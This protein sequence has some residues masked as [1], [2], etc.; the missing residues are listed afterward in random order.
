M[1]QHRRFFRFSVRRHRPR[2]R[3]RPGSGFRSGSG[4]KTGWGSGAPR[5]QNVGF[6]DVTHRHACASPDVLI[7]SRFEWFCGS[8]RTFQEFPGADPGAEPGAVAGL[9]D[10]GPV[11]CLFARFRLRFW[12]FF[13]SPT[14]WMRQACSAAQWRKIQL[15][16]Q[17]LI[18]GWSNQK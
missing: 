17:K 10:L 7:R 13:K 9:S 2:P 18:F 5:V 16:P 12:R 3:P 4:S 1:S 11:Y 6:V 8:S 15:Q 14:L